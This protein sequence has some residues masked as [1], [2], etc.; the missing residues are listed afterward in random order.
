MQGGVRSPREKAATICK[1][2]H[3]CEWHADPSSSFPRGHILFFIFL[4][5]DLPASESEGKAASG[6]NHT[7]YH[8]PLRLS[9]FALQRFSAEN[10]GEN[11]LMYSLAYTTVFCRHKLF[12]VKLVHSPIKKK[13]SVSFEIVSTLTMVEAF[14]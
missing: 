3:F 9:L 8:L 2:C 13:L 1:H 12:M 14:M 4:T 6:A 11:C 10:R 7:Q 5:A